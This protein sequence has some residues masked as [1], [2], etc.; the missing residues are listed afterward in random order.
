M[1]CD[2]PAQSAVEDYKVRG[3]HDPVGGPGAEEGESGGT[4]SIGKISA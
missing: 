3:G 4:I 1:F 2:S